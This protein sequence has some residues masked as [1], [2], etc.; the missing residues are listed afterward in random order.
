MLGLL[1]KANELAKQSREAEAGKLS[2]DVTA[3]IESAYD[4]ILGHARI[5]YAADGPIDPR[6]KPDGIALS[7]RLGQYRANHLAFIHDLTIPFTTTDPSN[8]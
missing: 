2:D 4:A 1:C 3:C 6:Y 8:C 5:E 7:T